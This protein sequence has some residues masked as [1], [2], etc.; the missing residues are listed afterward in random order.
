MYVCVC[1]CNYKFQLCIVGL[2]VVSSFKTT[3]PKENELRVRISNDDFQ[4]L[5]LVLRVPYLG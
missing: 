1:V 2:T 5:K 3:K 4:D